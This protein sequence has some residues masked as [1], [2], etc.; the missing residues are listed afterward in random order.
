M[1]KEGVTRNQRRNDD[2][3][4]RWF[5]RR[6]VLFRL[7]LLVLSPVLFLTLLEV[8]LRLIN[9]GY[10]THF[11]LGP[12]PLG[13]CHTNYRFG[14]RFFPPAIARSPHPQVLATK[15]GGGVRIFVLG[16]SAAMGIPDPGYGVC[17]I[18]EV[19]LRERYP[20]K[21]VEVINAAVTAINSH[22]VREIARDCA[23]SKP[24]VFVVYMGNNEVIGPYGP[25]TVFQRWTPSLSVIRAGIR[26]KSTRVGQFM[27][28]IIGVFRPGSGAPRRWRGL[29]MFQ[30]NCMACDDS[31]MERVYDHFRQNL[32]DI[33][34]IALKAD[35]GVVLST[36]AVNL[37]DFP[38]LVS[39][40]RAGLGG[41]SLAQ[42]EA[43]Y[44]AGMKLQSESRWQE[45]LADYE[46]AAVIDD[47]FAELQFRMG[48][49][50]LKT[51]R[52]AEAL[53]R[54][55]LARDLDVLRFRADS[56]IN[57][58]IRE[59]AHA[60]AAGGVRLVDA[61]RDLTE[62]SPG[63]PDNP[64]KKSFYEHVHLT[65]EGNYRLAR[66]LLE[67]VCAALSERGHPPAL[68]VIASQERCAERLVLTPWD[69]YR[70]ASKMVLLTAEKPFAGQKDYASRQA[71]ARQ[72]SDHLR[73][74]ASS[75][76]AKEAAWQAYARALAISGGDF[77]I[78]YHLGQ[79]A[80]DWNRP[81]AAVQPLKRLVGAM[82][83][84][85]AFRR[86]LGDAFSAQGRIGEAIAQYRK[87]LEL[88]PSDLDVGVAIGASLWRS[89]RVDEAIAEFHKVLTID[90]GHEQAH[91]D[92]GSA[93]VSLG[94]LDEAIQH[95]RRA[96]EIKPDYA[97][98]HQNLG[99]VYLQMGQPDAAI[100]QFRKAVAIKPDYA[101]VHHKL[102][103]LLA[104]QGRTDEAIACYEKALE[105]AVDDAVLHN[106]IGGL[107]FPKGR[108][109]EALS[110]FRKAIELKPDYMDA[111]INLA[112]AL[113]LAGKADDA[114][115]ELDKALKL[116]PENA[117]ARQMLSVL[118]AKQR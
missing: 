115:R 22:V 109:D 39:Q 4:L 46:K 5:R 3:C 2:S 108:R 73:K 92:L 103:V 53:P 100:A 62:G 82:P 77:D 34:S 33:C 71:S 14:W 70:M 84:E 102:G 85:P 30:Q 60:Q 21:H 7:S 1:K 37:L 17:R 59:I 23:A 88:T 16:E 6:K 40:H 99:A 95:Y 41:G 26:L 94:R 72:Q 64:A 74:T 36:V 31:R 66:T 9:H 61:A 45:A 49:C 75:A 107:V 97:E 15:P 42:W 43:A 51:D 47:R 68:D 116:Q 32:A 50:L 98:P 79:L 28:D 111:R 25:G 81:A 114:I 83:L 118:R 90:P 24:D 106:N 8:V 35:A 96:I 58:I 10:P 104:Q 78:Q 57:G 19:M 87:A 91:N 80:I 12:D 63:V 93:M 52:A 56:R 112:R 48:E 18:L 105:F 44:Y 11:F 117:A 76:K 29:E 20:G 86:T 67:Q 13:R 27:G 69:E 55:E 38:P 113:M 101:E 110:H 89:G 54:F 65:F